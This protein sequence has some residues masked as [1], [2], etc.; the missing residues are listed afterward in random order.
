MD[1]Q[2]SLF[3]S[4]KVCGS[5]TS[6]LFAFPILFQ[7]VDWNVLRPSA[8]SRVLLHGLHSINSLKPFESRSDERSSLGSSLK[9]VSPE[10]KFENHF[11]T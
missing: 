6:G 7:S 4:L 11:R 8:N 10:L 1:M 9:D 3:F 2:F 5:Q